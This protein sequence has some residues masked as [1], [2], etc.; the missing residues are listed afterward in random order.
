MSCASGGRFGRR[1]VFELRTAWRAVRWR[2]LRAYGAALAALGATA[3]FASNNPMPGPLLSATVRFGGAFAGAL[4]MA[5]LAQQLAV[6]RPVW[7]W[8][9]SLPHSSGQRILSDALILCLA[10]VPLL[11][12]A[13]LVDITGA[14][15][16]LSA[17][18]LLSVRAAGHMRRL[19][20]RKTGSS[21][22]LVEGFAIAAALALFSWSSLVW[23]AGVPA[24]F[25]A[26][27]RLET[28]QKVTRWLELHHTAAGDPMSWSG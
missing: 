24:A 25:G 23:L 26:A 19:P 13:S 1:N 4:F 5:I 10:A 15:T 18:P 3:L 2:V 11:V 8:A 20:E 27:R 6:R 12:C 28:R 14:L 22:V 17:M 21:V 16:S 7:P 9:R